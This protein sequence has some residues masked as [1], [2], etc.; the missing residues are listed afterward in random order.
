MV[1]KFDWNEE[2]SKLWISLIGN[3]SVLGIALGSIFG[4]PVINRG[5][6]RSMLA[7]T[8]V[9]SVGTGLSLIRTIPTIMI[10]RFIQGLA[11]GVVNNAV[12]KSI[13]ECT[14]TE[15]YA[16]FGTATGTFMSI[17]SLVCLLLG[18]SL[19]TDPEQYVHDETWRLTYAFPILVVL[20]LVVLL[21]SK[22]KYEPIDYSIKIGDTKNAKNLV[23]MLYAPSEPN[24]DEES[25]A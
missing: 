21:L 23:K 8:L 4:G 13:F 24:L 14:S 18:L 16:V 15:L 6:R 9:M 20:V 3:I 10:G 22:Y 19:P 25:N 12:A 17:G 1:A 2:E 5:R 7:M 11:G